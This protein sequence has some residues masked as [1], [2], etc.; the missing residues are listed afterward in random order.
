MQRTLNFSCRAVISLDLDLG[1]ISAFFSNK[2]SQ[3]DLVNCWIVSFDVENIFCYIAS[4]FGL[5]WDRNT[6]RGSWGSYSKGI[7]A[8]RGTMCII[9]S[10]GSY[11]AEYGPREER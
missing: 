11:S 6:H 9:A 1:Q 4:C 7:R 2:S 10:W 8:L 3:S 5:E